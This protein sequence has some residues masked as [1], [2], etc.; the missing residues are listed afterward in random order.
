MYTFVLIVHIITSFI[1]VG[2]I[3]FQAG[4][5]GGLAQ[6]FGGG[7]AS[8]TIFGQKTSVFLMRATTVSAVLF[9]CTSLSLA[10]ISSR[11]A[12]SLMKRI[13]IAPITDTRETAIPTKS[14][15]KGR[16]DL[17]TGK[18]EAVEEKVIP[19]TGG[20]RKSLKKKAEVPVKEPDIVK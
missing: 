17:E 1:L 20:G 12:K 8:T 14:A 19:L 10:V 16:I 3:L 13:K 18:E 15:R 4:R 6:T 5:G 2:V 7:G 9:L 11:R